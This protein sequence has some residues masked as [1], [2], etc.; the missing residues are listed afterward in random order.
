MSFLTLSILCV[1]LVL[2]KCAKRDARRVRRECFSFF[3][4]DA[5]SLS[6]QREMHLELAE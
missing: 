5:F 6:A 2:V 3:V 4:L 1:K